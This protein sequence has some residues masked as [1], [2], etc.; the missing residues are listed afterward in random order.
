MA[1]AASSKHFQ[2]VAVS[3]VRRAPRGAVGVADVYIQSH[4]AVQEQL[5]ASI[6]P[7]LFPGNVLITHSVWS[8][9]VREVNSELSQGH[10]H[11]VICSC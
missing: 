3:G 5:G 8:I 2:K 6:T 4:I 7:L 9:L 11:K 1:P 10:R